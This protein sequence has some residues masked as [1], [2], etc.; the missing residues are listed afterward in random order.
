MSH[1]PILWTALF[2]VLFAFFA[3]VWVLTPFVLSYL[4][5]VLAHLIRKRR[6]YNQQKQFTS[7]T[8]SKGKL[9]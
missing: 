3:T 8:K 2:V 6:K 4:D 1:D 7:S 5:D 9:Q